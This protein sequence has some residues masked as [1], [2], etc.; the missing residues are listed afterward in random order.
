LGLKIIIINV[1]YNTFIKLEQ[2]KGHYA[3][4]NSM[5][6]IGNLHEQ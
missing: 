6:R 4:L 3:S 1:Y 2:L 5:V